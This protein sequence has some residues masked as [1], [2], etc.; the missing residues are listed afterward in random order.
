MTLPELQQKER[1]LI[2]VLEFLRI[3]INEFTK[4]PCETVD[5]LQLNYQYSFELRNLKDVQQKIK[6]IENNANN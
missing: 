4:Y 2:S 1:Y 3:E 6:I 5:L